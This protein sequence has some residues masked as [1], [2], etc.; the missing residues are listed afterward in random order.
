M[1]PADWMAWRDYLARGRLGER[2]TAERAAVWNMTCVILLDDLQKHI[3][4][5]GGT[6]KYRVSQNKPPS[7]FCR[8]VFVCKINIMEI[9]LFSLKKTFL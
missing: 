7:S 9:P 1:L 6:V 5:I 2:G 4:W 8:K 3:N